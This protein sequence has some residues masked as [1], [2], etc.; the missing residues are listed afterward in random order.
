[1][2][3]SLLISSGAPWNLW[4][5]AILTACHLQ[6]R[7]PYKR[8][9]KTPYELWKGYKP[10]LTY[11]KVWGCFAKVLIPDPKR[12]RIGPKTIDCMFIGYA[13]NSAAYRFLILEDKEKI[14][15]ANTIIKSKAAELVENIFLEK[16][17]RLSR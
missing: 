8:T 14:F 15:D 11:L 2:M 4:G 17:C 5:E 3:N 7:I 9:G 16:S 13:Q 12:S 6:N 10:N 1:M